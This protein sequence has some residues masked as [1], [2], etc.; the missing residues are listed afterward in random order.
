LSAEQMWS[1][2]TLNRLPSWKYTKMTVFLVAP[3]ARR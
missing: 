1:E 3:F 2:V